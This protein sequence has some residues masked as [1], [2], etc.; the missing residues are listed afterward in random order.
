MLRLLKNQWTETTRSPMFQK[1]IVINIILGLFAAVML[2]LF[3]S[4]GFLIDK[5]LVQD[6]LVALYP[7][8]D[9]IDLFNGI[10]FS[11]FL[12]MLVIRFFMQDLPT[13]IIQPYLLLPV[14]RKKLVHY[15]LIKSSLNL[16]NVFPLLVF[17]PFSF[18]VV[19]PDMGMTAALTWLAVVFLLMLTNNYI[20]TYFKRQMANNM[21]YVAL[22]GVVIVLLNILDY[23]DIINLSTLSIIVF[24]FVLKNAWT[25][26]AVLA[27]V[28]S[29]YYANFHFLVNNTYLEEI[30]S[31]KA[32]K[33]DAFTN[34]KALDRFGE[35]GKLVTLE[36]KLMF[37]HKR[38]RTV[39]WISLIFLPYGLVFYLSDQYQGSILAYLFAGLFTTG[40]FLMNYGQ[41]LYSWESEHFDAVLIQNIDT[42]NYVKAKFA[43]MIPVAIVCSL[44][45]L[46]YGLIDPIAIPINLAATLFNIGLNSFVLIF[47]S[48]N[49]NKRLELTKGGTFNAQGVSIN[50]FIM[51]IPMLLFPILI[52]WLCSLSGDPYIGIAVVGGIGL[53]SLF[54]YDFWFKLIVKQFKQKKYRMAAGFRKKD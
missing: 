31:K 44:I 19:L 53:I 54:L 41:Y 17:I 25:V 51:M 32:E 48:T 21:K 40:M 45:S 1:N 52:Y 5:I 20:V 29:V 11:Y 10:L 38:T 26:G 14:S 36:I 27:L 42:K 34:M 18:K 46:L 6:E 39:L 47:L 3:G 15:L 23:Q 2:F 24:G 30:S 4:L 37:R 12:F 8:R 35:I 16:F 50:Q 7:D 22:F 28:V 43:L 33:A 13:L 49:N 9:P